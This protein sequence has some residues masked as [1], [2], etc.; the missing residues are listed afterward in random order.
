MCVCLCHLWPVWHLW[1]LCGACVAR[2]GENDTSVRQA[3]CRWTRGFTPKMQACLRLDRST[4][5]RVATKHHPIHPARWLDQL[6]L[7]N[8]HSKERQRA[9]CE[10]TERLNLGSHSALSGHPHPTRP[11]NITDPR[12][13]LRF[14]APRLQQG[15]ED[16]MRD[17]VDGNRL[18]LGLVSGSGHRTEPCSPAYSCLHRREAT[19]I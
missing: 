9:T 1:R 7:S 17:V 2:V 8:I 18:L 13:Q 5:C 4:P 11:G 10:W 6:I 12:C 14:G 3:C 15:Q 16:T 19:S